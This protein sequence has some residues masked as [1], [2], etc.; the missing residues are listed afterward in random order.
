MTKTV[1]K[2][3]E[4]A[5]DQIFTV[6]YETGEVGYYLW[7][8]AGLF[9]ANVR[10]TRDSYQRVWR[11][12][13][14]EETEND[15]CDGIEGVMASELSDPNDED[16]IPMGAR[17]EVWISFADRTSDEGAWCFGIERARDPQEFA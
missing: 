6:E 12:L 9:D 5:R 14:L 15:I 13:N 1:S 3:I 16:Y 11:F 2:C 10:L 17:V 7:G 8:F 4:G